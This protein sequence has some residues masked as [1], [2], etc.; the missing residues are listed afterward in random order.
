MNMFMNLMINMICLMNMMSLIMNIARKTRTNKS[1]FSK[2]TMHVHT[3]ACVHMVMDMRLH[4]HA[5]LP[6]NLAGNT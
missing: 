3:E 2:L 1:G 5:S 4:A 6:R